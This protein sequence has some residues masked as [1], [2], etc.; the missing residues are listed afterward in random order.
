MLRRFLLERNRIAASLDGN[1]NRLRVLVVE[2]MLLNECCEVVKK[3]SVGRKSRLAR[4]T[5]AQRVVPG[6]SDNGCRYEF[7]DLHKMKERVFFGTGNATA[8]KE[9]MQFC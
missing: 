6:H 3:S 1:A 7:N 4:E 5:T 2:P 9:A 8:N